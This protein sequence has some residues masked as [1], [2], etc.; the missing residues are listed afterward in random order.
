MCLGN[1]TTRVEMRMSHLNVA[2]MKLWHF[3]IDGTYKF[4]FTMYWNGFWGPFGPKWNKWQSCGK[5]FD[6]INSNNQ[7]LFFKIAYRFKQI[8]WGL[9]RCTLS[10]TPCKNGNTIE[11]LIKSFKERQNH[12]FDYSLRKL[13]IK[14]L[15][16]CH[17]SEAC[18]G[19]WVK[20][21]GPCPFFISSFLKIILGFK[22]RH[23]HG[24]CCPKSHTSYARLAWPTH[25]SRTQT[26]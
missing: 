26:R 21:L 4:Q 1:M 19:S 3:A 18:F 14:S 17:V 8:H 24:T 6:L 11:L 9:S 23:A 7:M 16:T 2:H 20:I 13:S 22:I 25:P 12:G 10:P 15:L 5:L